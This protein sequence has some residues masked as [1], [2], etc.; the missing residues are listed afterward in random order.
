M[1]KRWSFLDCLVWSLFAGFATIVYPLGNV[2]SGRLDALDWFTL[3]LGL[4]LQYIIWIDVPPKL[5]KW[6]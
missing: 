3:T 5:E 4:M 6:F 2:L 1:R